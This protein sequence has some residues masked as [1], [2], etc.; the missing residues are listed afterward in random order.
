MSRIRTGDRA[1]VAQ[2]SLS[3]RAPSTTQATF[4]IPSGYEFRRHPIFVA[5]FRVT[6]RCRPTLWFWLREL[7]SN[8]R[9]Q[10]HEACGDNN[11]APLPRDLASYTGF[12]PVSP[13]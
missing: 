7:D 5:G 3:R 9:S 8:Q 4:L 13:E 10:A 6:A 12:E 1:F 2:L 11:Q